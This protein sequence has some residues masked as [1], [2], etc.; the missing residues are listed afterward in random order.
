MRS[1]AIGIIV[2]IVVLLSFG[3]KKDKTI[4][5]PDLY[6]TWVKGSNHGDTLWF[7]KKNGQNIIRI[8]ESF[9]P[10]MPL[11]SEKEYRFKNGELSIRSFA[12]ASQEYF[13]ITSFTWTD[14]GKEFTILN[15]N[16]FIFM[17]SM[18]TYKYKK[19]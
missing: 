8:P 18:V 6:G 16:L 12:P 17:S 11:Y 1:M 14:Q 19:I 5:E 9:N 13:P 4:D 15:I 10:L 7:M 2:L 3:C